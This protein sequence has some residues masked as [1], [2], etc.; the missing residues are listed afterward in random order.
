MAHVLVIGAGVSG[1]TAAYRIA[2]DGVRVTLVE[3]SGTIGGRVRHYGCKATDKCNNCGVCLVGGLW[4]KVEKN[5][6]IETV[7]FSEVTD[8]SGDAGDFS[9]TVKTPSGPRYL[10][11]LDSVVVSTG[12]E[13][14]AASETAHL[15]VEQG[16]GILTGSEIEALMLDRGKNA[17]LKDEP[18][19]VAFIQCFGSRDEKERSNY[20]SRVCCSYST[21]AAKVLRHYYPGCEIAFFYMELQNVA[22]R[23]YF[24]EL[25]NDKIEFIKCRPLKIIGGSP[26][27]IRYDD[28]A[29]GMKTR[30][31]DLIVLS[32]GVHPG[33]DSDWMASIYGLGQDDNGF[34]RPM[35]ER[36]GLYVAGCARAPMKIDESYADSLAV[37]ETITACRG[38]C[39][40]LSA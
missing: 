8:V 28:P 10:S 30:S 13:S 21:R 12:F 33:S 3:K 2:Q 31:F 34:L 5:P 11:R 40:G 6:L 29:E 37:A 1:C 35:E 20:C 19:S 7:L 9:A 38:L 27:V 36:E 4:E 23:D 24:K 18:K 16:A 22:A 17:W 15:Q 26:A 39:G 14:T 25:G 32:E